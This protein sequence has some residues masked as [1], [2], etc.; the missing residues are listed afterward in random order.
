MSSSLNKSLQNISKKLEQQFKT[1]SDFEKRTILKGK[2]SIYCLNT[3][4]DTDQIQNYIIEPLQQT[5][6]KTNEGNLS[7]ED[8]KTIIC[9]LSLKETDSIEQVKDALVKG[10]TFL[11]IE[12]A[13][14]GLLISTT[15]WIERGLEETLGERSVKGPT[16]GLTENLTTNINILRRII[17]S[18]QLIIDTKAYGIHLKTDISI[19]YINNLVNK[20]ILQE[21]KK[22]I[23]T[24]NVDYILHSKIVEETL[25]GKSE[26]FTNLIMTTQRVD[27]TTSALLE[28]KV[29][30]L[31]NGIP[32]SIITPSLFVDFFQSPDDFHVKAG[33]FVN[34]PI[35][36]L[37]YIA[38]ILIPGI[39]VG[40]EKFHSDNFSE[41]TQKK[42]FNNG[43]LL[44]TFWEM[45]ILLILFR[46]L[47]DIGSRAPKGT[48][49]II[50]LIATIVIGEMSVTANFVH[51]AGLIA[52][53]L[54]VYLSTLVIYRG[55]VG[56]NVL[57]SVFFITCY[58]FDLPSIMIVSTL[59]ILYFTQLKS[60]GVPYLSPLIPFRYWEFQDIFI[61]GNLRKLHNKSH[62]FPNI[63]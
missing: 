34:R 59:V 11:F 6:K 36:Y 61:R 3:I 62:K 38:S 35:R 2:I 13:T 14:S 17:Q 19:I 40:L 58:Y 57:R 31:V 5:A 7:I 55:E 30:V 52:A 44:P 16:V 47:I 28:G 53:G 49:I 12:G 24:I 63:K 43:E 1:T 27:T 29:I 4:V 21:V 18:P 50:T 9:S 33:R 46:I 20:H 22:R 25:E 32:F 37:G 42:V 56:I 26:T 15:K 39:Y 51:P 10:E 54:S 48:I 8:I 45:A 41:K 60:V 23:D